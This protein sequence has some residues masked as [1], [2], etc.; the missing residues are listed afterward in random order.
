MRGEPVP[1]VQRHP[2]VDGS[3]HVDG[4]TVFTLFHCLDYSGCISCVLS[5]LCLARSSTDC[6]RRTCCDRS[7]HSQI[8][9]WDSSETMHVVKH[10]FVQ[11]LVLDQ[12]NRFL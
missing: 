8:E 6:D 9:L 1:Q 12:G 5:V 11:H 10:P 2:G 3:Q 7:D 4:K